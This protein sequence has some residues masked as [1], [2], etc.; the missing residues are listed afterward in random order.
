MTCI[1]YNEFKGYC[2]NTDDDS[3]FINSE[4]LTCGINELPWDFYLPNKLIEENNEETQQQEQCNKKLTKSEKRGIRQSKRINA[5]RKK[6]LQ[7]AN[8]NDEEEIIQ[9][10]SYLAKQEI[11]KIYKNLVGAGKQ[12]KKILQYHSIALYKS[13]IEHF[14]PNEWFND[15]NI[16]MIYELIKNLFITKQNKQFS[17]QIV[18][19]FPSLIQ[20]FLHFP[21]DAQDLLPLDDLKKSKFIFLPI[22]FIDEPVEMDLE[23]ANNGDHWV[24][25]ILSLLDNTL[26]IYDSMKID[27]DQVSE[28]QLQN[29]IVKFENCKQLVHGKI[30]IN[31]IETDQQKNFDDCGVYVIMISC[32]LINQ[33]IFQNEINLDI[34]KIKFN[35]LEA[36]LYILKTLTRLVE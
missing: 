15:N 25:G 18:L 1:I 7:R 35:P 10:N 28:A 30:K 21:G 17:N 2:L 24:L 6:Q 32:F 19:L 34:S 29:L 9:F 33:F 3:Q 5:S 36:R 8:S 22:N 14:L 13:D 20:L 23:Q 12:D 26:Y 31:Y 11:K 4:K 16:S 27:D